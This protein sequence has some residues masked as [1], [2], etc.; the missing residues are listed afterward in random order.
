MSLAQLNLVDA[1]VLVAGE[2]VDFET[3]QLHQTMSGHH[4]FEIKVNYRP[5]KP[6]VWTVT[7]EKLFEQLGENLHITFTHK[8][9]GE[10]TE[11]DGI[12][13]N[14]N[15]EGSNGDQGYVVLQGGSPTILLDMDPSMGG[16]TEY[17]L[18]NIVSEVLENSGVGLELN[19]QAQF[20]SIIPYAARYKE[21]SFAFLSR[22][23]ASCGDWFY[24]DGSKLNLGNPNIENDTRAA[25]DMELSKIAISAGLGNLNMELYDYDA[26]TND[27]KEDAP[28]KN[29]EGINS[30]M[31]VAL[32]KSEPLFP[33]VNKMATNR[34]M[35]DENDIVA[36]M[37]AVYSKKYSKMSVFSAQSNTCAIRLGELVTTRLPESLQQDVGPDLGR[38]RVLEIHHEIDQSGI[39]RNTFKGVA[40]MTET[41]PTDHIVQPVAFPELAMV[42]ENQ[43]P[44]ALG[45]VKV[46]FLWMGDDVTTNW[47]RVQTS[48]IGVDES[49]D[50]LH[51]LYFIPSL[52]DQVMVSFEHGDP[53]RPYVSGSLVHADNAAGVQ[54]DH[55]ISK[56]VTASGHTIELN[57]TE[58]EETI[59]I[60]DN[61]GS[62]I[63]FDT[64]AKSL[65]INAT[66]TIDIAAKNI[67]ITAEEN[68][69][70]GAQGNIDIA[71]EGDL[72]NQAQGNVSLQSDGDTTL[73]SSGAVAVEA[74]SDATISG[75]N[76]VIEG[77]VGAELNGAQT[78]VTGSA[79]TE[80]SGGI[81]K[82][83]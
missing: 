10:V 40:G 55:T 56:I 20:T 15:V 63:I 35:V 2:A 1:E 9:S 41:I 8:E 82:L 23:A 61:E 74:T 43:D 70:I 71:A 73:K 69:T 29:I 11:F 32:D 19:N 48:N 12:I 59:K 22:M 28:V 49:N 37:R 62:I 36:Q 30:Y 33:N 60:Y 81:I 51:G 5:D 3:L 53:S 76:A 57:D 39:Y 75:M 50:G 68:I 26:V 6:T 46:R 17:T 13:T 21:T 47:I 44:E 27:Y 67:N 58:G 38:Y 25:F 45:R 42:V 52:N 31:R 54:A 18:S 65:T 77:S 14:V 16:Y 80:V 4:K 79:M 7:P 78:K 64:Q 72:I 24:Y 34:A 83:N 66:E